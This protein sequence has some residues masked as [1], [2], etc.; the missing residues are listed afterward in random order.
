MVGLKILPLSW[1]DML[2]PEFPPFMLD[3]LEVVDS[4]AGLKALTQNW[5]NQMVR[6]GKLDCLVLS[7]PAVVRGTTGSREGILFLAKWCLTKRRNKIHNN[8][9]GCGGG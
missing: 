1:S 5:A 2:L 7:A 6:F 8:I 9:G 3:V 4:S